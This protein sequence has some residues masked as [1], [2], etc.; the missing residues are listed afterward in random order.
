MPNLP[1]P[2]WSRAILSAAIL[3]GGCAK[4][5]SS[6]LAA[7]REE[8]AQLRGEVKELAK[9]VS[10]P[11]REP[12]EVTKVGEQVLFRTESGRP[13]KTAWLS[14]T[15][16]LK[17]RVIDLNDPACF[18]QFAEAPGEVTVTLIDDQGK[19]TKV[20]VRVLPADAPK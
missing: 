10:P 14:V 12:D 11:R 17:S 2:R 6:D 3:M 7:L 13:I 20:R 1:Q 15:G 18:L 8:I 9:Q 16:V 5:T 4:D 19:V